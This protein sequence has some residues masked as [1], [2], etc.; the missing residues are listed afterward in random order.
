MHVVLESFQVG[1]GE[2]PTVLLHGFLGSGRNLR[3]LAMAWSEAEPQRR[4]L[5]PDLTGHGTSPALP[6]GADLDTLARDVHETAR[7]QGFTGPVD[8]VGHSLGGRVSLAASLL[9]PAEVARVTLLD[10]TPSPVP[11]SL[12]E[13]GMVLN[14]LM[15]APD[16]APSRKE[17]RADLMGRGLSAGLADWLVMNLEPT[18][19]G[20]VRWRFGR[21][22]LAELH[23]RVNQRDLWAAVERPGAKVRC[24]RGGRARYV[25]DEDLARL[26]RAGCPVATLPEA[27]HFV[28]VEALPALLQWLLQAH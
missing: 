22:A 16:T 28:H 23:G 25:P 10:I 9:F 11:V 1:E 18:P 5:L 21:Q 24:I 4:F 19:E 7:A 12:M 26:E 8:W 15:Q 17:M 6:P 14:L 20:G 27:G 13:S 3:S 2:V